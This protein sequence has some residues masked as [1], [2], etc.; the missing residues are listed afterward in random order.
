LIEKIISGGQTG[1]DRAGLDAALALGIPHGGYCPAGRLCENG[2]IPQKY[3]LIEMGSKKY[4]YRT[5]KNVL[6]S[7]GTIIFTKG[8]LSRGSKLTLDYCARHNKPC[9][10]FDFNYEKENKTKYFEQFIND[11]SIEVL[12]IAGQRLTSE[13]SIYRLT[14][15]FLLKVIGTNNNENVEV[16]I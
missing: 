2:A 12:N 10:H 6:S 4:H 14:Y 3:N 9:L 5:E 7:D 15:N 8:Q 13:K 1:A 11:Y 16:T